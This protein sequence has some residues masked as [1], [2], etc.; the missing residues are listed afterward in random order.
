MTDLYDLGYKHAYTGRQ[1]AGEHKEQPYYMHG[2]NNGRRDYERY[3]DLLDEGYSSHQAQVMA[4]MRDPV[5][6]AE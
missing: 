5:E 1:P 4:G 6:A 3:R 2:Y